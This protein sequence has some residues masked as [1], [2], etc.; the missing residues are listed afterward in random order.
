MTKLSIYLGL[1]GLNPAAAVAV[2]GICGNGR[3]RFQALSGVLNG[4][5]SG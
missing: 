2:A 1:I 4:W 3:L 5:L